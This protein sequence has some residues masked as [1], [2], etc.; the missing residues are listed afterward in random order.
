MLKAQEIM[1]ILK[2]VV[3]RETGI[4]ERFH[5]KDKCGRVSQGDFQFF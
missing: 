2:E 3:E 5:E 4:L 1:N